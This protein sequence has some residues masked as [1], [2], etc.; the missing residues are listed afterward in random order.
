MIPA[1]TS[2]GLQLHF[3][4]NVP[5]GSTCTVT[6]TADGATSV[7]TATV[8]GGNNR[9][10]NVPAGTIVPVLF[11]D[12]FTDAPGTLVVTQDHQ[13]RGS[14]PARADRHPG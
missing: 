5:A 12:I 9:T 7:V 11:T 2:A 1:G 3:Y 4:N 6:E 10:V 13:R 14:R 8:I